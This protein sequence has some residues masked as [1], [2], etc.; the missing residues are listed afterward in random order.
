L[1]AEDEVM[2]L[3]LVR[4][5]LERDGYFVLAAENGEEALMLSNALPQLFGRNPFAF[6]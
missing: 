3:N 1:I 4:I 5:T 6:V 2:I